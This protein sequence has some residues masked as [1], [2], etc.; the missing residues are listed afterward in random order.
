LGMNQFGDIDANEWRGR[1]RP[2]PNRTS[3]TQHRSAPRLSTG[4][5]VPA[6]WDWRLHNA[7][8][9]VE[10]QGQ[11]GAAAVYSCNDAA[12]GFGA[13]QTGNL[14]ITSV[15]EIIDCT[16]QGC[17]GGE[18]DEPFQWVVSNGGLCVDGSYP[19]VQPGTCEASNCTN[20]VVIHGYADVPSGD[21]KALLSAVATTV[22]STAIEA[23]QAIF[24][25]YTGGVLD[26]PGCGTQP[27]HVVTN[28][29]WGTDAGVD[30]WIL[31]NSWGTSWGLNGY[32]LVARGKNMC[33]V[34]TQSAYF[35]K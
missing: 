9:P 31:K 20:A 25:F 14:I 24:Q 1:F 3:T 30:Y 29:G 4:R 18:M 12:D 32:V 11:C 34:A 6:A 17:N 35:N 27:D 33:G 7:V 5:K 23:D 16:T 2:L 10:N 22:A 26:D 19:Y 28:V 13:I 15:Q 21:E 8:G